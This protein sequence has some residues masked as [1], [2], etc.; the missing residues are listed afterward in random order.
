MDMFKFGV[1]VFAVSAAAPVI[2]GQGPGRVRSI[3]VSSFADKRP[4]EG[5]G[6]GP[7]A[8]GGAAASGRK[9]VEYRFAGIVK[10]TPIRPAA[11]MKSMSNMA[12]IRPKATPADPGATTDIGVTVWRLRP[13]LAGE[14]SHKLPVKT[15]TGTEMWTP[16][17]VMAETE[18]S[19]GDRVRFA[20]ESTTPGFLY[21]FDGET[22]NS[23]AVGRPC[24]IFPAHPTDDNAVVPGLLVD[25]PGQEENFPY[26]LMDP[27]KESY[28]GEMVTVIVSPKK[29]GFLKFK[30]I[31]GCN[32][33]DAS[34]LVEIT[35]GSTAGLYSRGDTEDAVYTE[36]EA[37]SVCGTRTR[38]LVREKSES[39]PCGD[40]IRQLSREDPTPQSIYR[41]QAPRGSPA[42]ASFRLTVKR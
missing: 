17:R 11:P 5:K 40:Q 16:Q 35:S 22:D 2:C 18:F 8:A 34:Q 1:F 21:I 19:A 14:N 25:V 27:R 42:A 4:A 33:I 24:L 30:K 36:S 3:T 38:E 39:R 23:G 31:D 15:P 29:L 6:G 41:V 12:T 9:N 10:G 32:G 13:P 20:V 28:G 26:F 7:A 37:K